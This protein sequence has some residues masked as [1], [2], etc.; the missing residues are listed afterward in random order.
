MQLK[1]QLIGPKHQRME[2]HP[3]L[4]TKYNMLQVLM[5]LLMLLQV[6][7]KCL[8]IHLQEQSKDATIGSSL[9]R[10]TQKVMA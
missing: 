3:S 10:E 5:A 2:E 9:E 1:S 4:I 8:R 6:V 7:C